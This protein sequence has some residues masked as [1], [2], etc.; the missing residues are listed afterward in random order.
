MKIRNAI[1]LVALA[2][3]LAG[4]AWSKTDEDVQNAKFGIEVDK[5]IDQKAAANITK[6]MAAI[7]KSLAD[8]KSLTVEDAYDVNG[9]KAVKVTFD[10]NIM[11]APNSSNLSSEEKEKLRLFAQTII[12]VASETNIAVYGHTDNTGT[13]EAN[14]KISADRAQAVA[15]QLTDNGISQDRIVVKGL[16]YDYPIDDNAMAEGRRN[17]RRVEVFIS[18]NEKMIEDAEN[19]I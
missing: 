8:D 10:S 12:A 17:N 3:C 16:S 2:L 13:H 14:A 5:R 11:F 19:G 7:K 1:T 6:K 15:N 18:A 4:N 9:L